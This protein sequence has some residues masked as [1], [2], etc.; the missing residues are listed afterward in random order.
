[1]EEMTFKALKYCVDGGQFSMAQITRKFQCGYMQAVQIAAELENLGYVSRDGQ[2]GKYRILIT[3]EELNELEKQF[4]S[5]PEDSQ[6]SECDGQT[7]AQLF[8][9]TLNIKILGIGAGGIRAVDGFV[10]RK[11]NIAECFAVGDDSDAFNNSQCAEKIS[12][13][14]SALKNTAWRSI[15]MASKYKKPLTNLVNGANMVILVVGS[16]EETSTAVAAF[17]AGIAKKKGILTVAVVCA[18]PN[19]ESGICLADS[20]KGLQALKRKAD[21]VIVIQ[22]DDVCAALEKTMP[23]NGVRKPSD[24]TIADVLNILTAPLGAKIFFSLDISRIA[25]V[26][27]SSDKMFFGTGIGEGENKNLEALKTALEC[28][29]TGADVEKTK[30]MILYI[31]AGPEMVLSDCDEIMTFVSNKLPDTEIIF[32]ADCK[33]EFAGKIKVSILATA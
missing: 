7:P 4:C 30:K 20:K 5:E 14:Q 24:Q 26:F 19:T 8:C 17:I 9:N 6:N 13:P 23:I 28:P 31:E 29:I 11:T 15:K 12:L 27:Q 25:G 16:G 2:T 18:P 1:M 22:C 3:Q 21:S 10:E 32:T 33:E